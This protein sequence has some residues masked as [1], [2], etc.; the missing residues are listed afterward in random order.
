[1]L[2]KRREKDPP[3]PKPLTELAPRHSYNQVL[4]QG[5]NLFMSHF[6]ELS[7]EEWL[8]VLKRSISE[9]VIDGVLFPGFPEDEL[10]SG[11]H[12]SSGADGLHGAFEFYSYVREKTYGESGTGMRFLDFAAGW[13]RI[14]RF[15]MR[16]F[17]L[18]DLWAYEP[19][20]LFCTVARSIN[21]YVCFMT[22]PRT[23]DNTLP[24]GFF[25]IVVGYSIFS[26]LSRESA[27]AWLAEINR[28]MKPGG[29]C[30]MTTWGRR[31]LDDLRA[32]EVQLQ[33]GEDVHWYTEL[34]VRTAGSLKE[35]IAEYEAGQ[36]V[37]FSQGD[38]LY[39]EAFVSPD[40]LTRMIDEEGLDFE[41]VEFDRTSIAQ[42]V[43]VLRRPAAT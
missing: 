42:D 20:R 10:Q 8:E 43:F 31:F 6:G 35:R 24:P 19:D 1:M 27:G 11:I 18:E 21:P 40:A 4:S 39:G 23:P 9:P 12:G 13:G 14:S 36:F 17:E 15:F 16:D 3:E 26:H 25:D 34:C 38:A 30:V 41:L 28:A 5:E 7:E 29:Q 32:A 33:H 2:R 22:G 37:Y